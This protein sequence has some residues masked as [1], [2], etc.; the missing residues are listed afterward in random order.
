M[1][2]DQSIINEIK[3]KTD[4]LDL[5]SEYVKLEKRGRNYIGLCPFHDEKTPSFTV[6]E[7]KQICHCF[8]CKKGGNVFQFTQ[9]I[10]DI[11]FV[12]AV[13]ELGDRVNVAVDIEATQSNSNVQ[14][15][16]DDLQMIE[17]HELIQEFYY[18]ALTKTVEGEQALTY[19]QERGFTDALIKERGIGFAPDS[20][21]FCHDF[22]QKKGY[23]IELAYEAGLLSRNEENFS[24]YDRFRNRIMFP[25]KNA[26]GRIVGYSGRTYTGQEPKYLNSPETPIFQKRKLLYNLDK[27]RKSIRKLDEIVLLEGFMDV[28]KSDTAG[29]KN[30]V[31][32][33]GTQ[34]SDEHITFIRKLTSNITLM[35]DGDFAGSEAT[36]K[37]GQHLLQQG[38]NVF[39][40]QLPS[41]MDPDE[42]IGKYG[43]DAF[44]TFVKNDKK[45]FAHYKVSI[46]KDEIA[47]NDLS[48]E[49]YLK[50]LSHDIS[51]MKSSILQQKA[52]NDV[53]PFF[54]VSPEQLANEIQFNQAPANYYPEDEYGGYDEYGSYIEPE[55][56]G[57]AQFD[58][59]S[60]QEKAE[61]A[62]LKHLMRDKDTFLNYYE[63]VDKDNFTNQH[64]KYVFEVLHDFYAEND[65]YNI[66]DAVQYVNSNELRETLISLE[67]YNLNDEPYENEIDDYVNVI[68]EKGQ[69]TIESLNHKLREATRIGD[70]ELQKYYLQQI[71]AKN[72]ERM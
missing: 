23:D 43:N 67:Q 66:S 42:Y 60:R 26:Q 3:D 15:A 29:L 21:H 47:H 36:L 39:V 63:S 69:E 68:N 70:V 5:V 37:T 71:V 35:F 18:Y 24:Y 53:A 59:L 72:K 62:F 55:P 4:I 45:S 30:V 46:L 38:L 65:Q 2:I 48:Y 6:S 58:N 40:I 34:L 32:T 56:I 22:L 57:M 50:E 49:R 52:I 28:I 12:E 10:K 33:M 41:G 31:A 19:L 27:A 44:T 20:S 11:S 64:F 8:G 13:K 61:R 25:L 9:E 14:I 1:R 51:L 54:N 7:D 16:S 17:M